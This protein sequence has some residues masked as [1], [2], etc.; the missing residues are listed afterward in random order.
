MGSGYVCHVL[1]TRFLSRY[2]DDD[3]IVCSQE[4]TECGQLVS[5][6]Q[7]DWWSKAGGQL[8]HTAWGKNPIH[9]Q[10]NHNRIRNT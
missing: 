1:W 10:C 5:L 6:K 2:D 3:A 4:N 8:R 7:K 9:S